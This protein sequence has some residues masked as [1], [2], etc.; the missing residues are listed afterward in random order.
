MSFN[1]DF[2]GDRPAMRD[3]IPLGTRVLV[4]MTYT[5]GG[6][7]PPAD[8]KLVNDPATRASYAQ[9]T[10]SKPP[11]DAY[12]LKAEFT[13]QRGPYK[14]RKFWEN[15]TTQGGKLDEKG[16]SIAATITR[17]TMRSIIDAAQ[18]LSSKDES[19]AASARRVLPNGFPSFQGFTFAVKIGVEPAKGGF[20]EKNKLGTVLTVDSKDFPKSEADLDST[21][22]TGAPTAAALP[23]VAPSWVATAPAAVVAQTVAQAPSIAP[24]AI[25]TAAVLTEAIVLAT[26]APSALPAWMQQAGA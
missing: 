9:L 13:V 6:A 8:H 19:P 11:S 18:G 22:F 5:P 10:K 26:A 23:Q 7:T 21:G 14:G 25:A 17:G 2:S 16:N 3:V 12:Y 15:M 20:A 1:M 4:R 24:L